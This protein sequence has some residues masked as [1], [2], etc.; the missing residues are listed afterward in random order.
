[1]TRRYGTRPCSVCGQDIEP[2]DVAVQVNGVARHYD[3]DDVEG[4]PV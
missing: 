3:C 2:G 1:M 4:A